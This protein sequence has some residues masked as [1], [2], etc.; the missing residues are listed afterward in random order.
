MQSSQFLEEN[1]KLSPQSKGQTKIHN[2]FYQIW[3]KK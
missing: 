2:K 3:K 1:L